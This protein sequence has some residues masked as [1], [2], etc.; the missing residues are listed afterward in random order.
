M[1]RLIE[2]LAPLAARDKLIKALD[3]TDVISRWPVFEGDEKV[4]AR[5]LV[6]VQSSGDWIDTIETAL[7]GIEDYRLVLLPVE[8]SVPR[9][10]KPE[11]TEAESEA[12]KRN[13]GIS[14]D[15][16]IDELQEGISLGFNYFAFVL[17]SVLVAIVGLVQDNIAVIVGAMV[18]APL[19]T[20]NVALALATTLGDPKLARQALTAGTLGAG[21]ALLVAMVV[22]FLGLSL[23]SQQLLVRTEIRVG[24]VLVA[25]AAGAAGVL[26]LT[27]GASSSLIGVMVAVALMP[28]LVAAG[29]F[30]GA[31]QWQHAY[32]AGSLFAVNL[33]AVNLAGV[34]TFLVRGIRPR[35]WWQAARA[36]RSAWIA[37]SIW[38]ALLLALLLLL[39]A[40]GV[41]RLFVD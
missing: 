11:P 23:D 9:E 4:C 7:A 33:L 13:G 31:G 32:A 19:L 15:E 38:A 18:L 21:L 24:D 30:V 41:M 40:T 1:Y 34:L 6:Q 25:L 26:A 3:D 12:P 35:G 17:I 36:E 29:L 5:L 39:N 2:V 37:V 22:G 28:P 20:P 16:L 10:P 27:G 14:R 8:A